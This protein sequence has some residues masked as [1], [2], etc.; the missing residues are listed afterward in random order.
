MCWA[1]S[2]VIVRSVITL[3]ASLMLLQLVS[4]VDRP[5]V[6]RFLNASNGQHIQMTSRVAFL[7]RSADSKIESSVVDC[8]VRTD[9][10][11]TDDR[12][13]LCLFCLLLNNADVCWS[14]RPVRRW[15]SQTRNQGSIGL[16]GMAG[17]DECRALYNYTDRISTCGNKKETRDDDI[18]VAEE[19]DQSDKPWDNGK[20]T[21]DG[22]EAG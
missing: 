11:M 19:N 2:I 12:R 10:G 20:K 22:N 5:V 1:Y 18:R 3:L 16:K 8:D 4:R 9:E 13:G 15:E 14:E 6:I 7:I 21:S 17:T